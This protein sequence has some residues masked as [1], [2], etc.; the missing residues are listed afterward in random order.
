[1]RT[2][3]KLIII[4]G[5]VFCIHNSLFSQYVE[6]ALRYSKPNGM[7]SAR[8]AAMGVSYNGLIDDIGA[9]LYNPAGLTLIGKS[10]L[11]LGLGFTRNS[12][13]TNYLNTNDLFKTNNEFITNL[14]LASAFKI[15]NKKAAIGIGYFL[16][17]DF[18]NS[19]K[20]NAFNPNSTYINSE[21]T[22]GPQTKDQ[23]WASWL[24][25]ADSV[26]SKFIT[27]YNDS[28]NQKSFI[29]ESGGLHNI[30]GAMAFDVN[31]NVTL[32][33]SISGKWGTYKY[34]KEYSES[35]DNNY[36]ANT[37]IEGHNFSKLES[38]QDLS[39]KV[40]G[41]TGAIGVQARFEN[42][43]RLSASI[44]FPTW[45]Q[46]DE[47]FNV[48]NTASYTNNYKSEYFE[49]NGD[50]S[51]NMT[52]PFV[53]SA[54]VS[55]N[56]MG[57]T[58]AVGVE[59]TDVTQIEFS[60]AISEVMSLNSVIIQELV[61]QTTWGFG[62]EYDPQIIPIVGRISFSRTTSPYFK[63][64]PN[65][66]KSDFAIGAGVYLSQNVRLDGVFKWTDY[67]EQRTNYYETGVLA[68]SANY[69][70]KNA[71]L[72]IGFTITYRY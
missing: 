37:F 46:F 38:I 57:L 18:E 52:S 26:N 32:G 43:M 47:N 19:M 62:L 3:L 60:D 53:Y 30:T 8:V 11:S 31:E 49:Y 61:G 35:D 36:F 45:Y 68:N 69:I 56:G 64:I 50:N 20:F 24:Y 34:R 40:S 51:Y 54:G 1:M 17:S 27:P 55:V 25:L 16:E 13:E 14:G 5:A 63:D 41:I 58:F 12:A 23:N 21:A 39:Q 33:M 10:E 48:R 22:Y 42:F 72:N 7:I 15:N 66:N 44:K 2:I 71:P 4:V 28:L 9:L 59:Y 67:A 29:K 65:A 70:L 6:D